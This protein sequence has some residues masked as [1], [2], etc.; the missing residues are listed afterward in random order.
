MQSLAAAVFQVPPTHPDLA[1]AMDIMLVALSA[2]PAAPQPQQLLP[3]VSMEPPGIPDSDLELEEPSD[4]QL[5]QYFQQLTPAERCRRF[6]FK[7]RPHGRTGPYQAPT[8]K[9]QDSV[10]PSQPRQAALAAALAS[11]ESVPQQ[12]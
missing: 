2:E 10:E 7:K 12:A 6:T 5:L 9:Q 11:Q 1:Q 3:D 8:T 4:E